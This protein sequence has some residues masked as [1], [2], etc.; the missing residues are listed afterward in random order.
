M[1]RLTLKTATE[2]EVYLF[3]QSIILLGADTNHVDLQLNGSEIHSIHLKIID[4]NGFPIIINYNNDPFTTV[5]GHSFGKKLLNSGDIIAIHQMTILFETLNLPTSK[6]PTVQE[7][8]TLL[9]VQNSVKELGSPSTPFVLPFEQEVATLN[10]E[11]LQKQSI[12]TYLK[13][14]ES[15]VLKASPAQVSSQVKDSQ[16]TTSKPTMS[17]KD[18]YMKSLDVDN[19]ENFPTSNDEKLDPYWTLKKFFFLIIF[20]G[21]ISGIGGIIIY[22]KISDDSERQESRA[23]QGVADIAMALVHA[24][25]NHLSP[26]NQNWSDAE[27]LKNNLQTLLN[28]F[29]YASQI[30]AEGQFNCCPY[31]LRIYTNGDLSHFLLIAQPLPNLF[32]LTPPSIIVVDSH[33]MQLYRLKDVRILNRLLANAEPL[34]GPNG[35]E[36]T[37]LVNESELIPLSVLASPSD[38]LDFNPP[39]SLAQVRPGAE[40][41]IY[42]APRYYRLSQNII[43]K[44]MN[45]LSSNTVNQEVADLKRIVDHLNGL[46][47]VVLYSEQGKKLA[48]LARRALMMFAPS[49]KLLFGY[50]VLNPQGKIAQV[51]LLTDEEINNSA[52]TSISQNDVE[53]LAYE[54]PV[55]FKEEVSKKNIELPNIDHT[56]PLFMQLQPL[57]LARENELRPLI[58]ALFT[59]T[60]QE[61]QNPR[62]QFQIEYQNLS[63]SYLMTH[64]KHQKILKENI[65]RLSKQ[66]KDMPIHQF[67]SFIN[68]LHLGQLVLQ[69]DQSFALL[70]ENCE[71]NMETLLTYVDNS[72]S[73]AELN[74]IIH[75]AT[76]WL[77]FDY[78]KDAEELLR[79]QNRI[80]NQL[81]EQLEDYLL[82]EKKSFIPKIE[83][84]EILLD[85]LNH[86]RLIKTEERDFFIG[87]FEELLQMHTDR[88]KINPEK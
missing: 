30:D 35:H 58:T 56:H 40:T 8:P 18:E 11:E 59:L 81:L 25:V 87:E 50:L 33:L 36:I 83:D 63:H 5:N 15:E 70:D 62:V 9:E 20:L 79:Y 22:F 34:D 14:V 1:I 85:I 21:A 76:T 52:L 78:I 6:I 49:D 88:D 86:E 38:H 10:N 54:P 27:F 24:Q 57:I 77:N 66:Y 3:N 42:N 12:E 60:D 67:L 29:S 68:K 74:N 16:P 80:R 53:V 41:L 46:H 43:H 13:E 65:D 28:S 39:E 45:L 32:W 55:E 84:R 7:N 73:L 64:A 47:H 51:H 44:A 23:A 82:T 17:L 48:L 26:N 4:Q 69:N 37:R 2:T 72:K 19:N 61:L 71:Q 31:N 75:V